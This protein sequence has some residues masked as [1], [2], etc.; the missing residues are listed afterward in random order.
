MRLP[1]HRRSLLAGV[2]L[3]GLLP[4]AAHAT[5][6]G[7][8]LDG[9]PVDLYNGAST[10]GKTGMVHC[11]DGDGLPRRD[12]EYRDGRQAGTMRWFYKGVLQKESRTNERGNVDG[13]SRT[14]AATPGQKNQLM[15]EETGRNGTTVGL[16]RDWY[17]DGMLQRLSWHLDDGSE[18]AVAGFTT[19]GK[20]SDLRCF[21]QPVFAPDFDDVSACGFKGAKTVELF[22]SKGWL[23]ARVVFDH[24]ERRHIENLWENGKPQQVVELGSA[25]GSEN[26][27][28]ED[29]GKRRTVA[30]LVQPSGI[31]GKPGYR[32]VTLQQDFH[33]SGTLVRERHWTPNGRGADLALDETW[34]LNGQLKTKD[35]FLLQDGQ[36]VKRATTFF[37]NGKV[38]ATGVWL[39]K[40]EYDDHPIGVH[41]RF[42]DQGRLRGE[43]SYDARGRLTRER[44]LDESGAVVTDDQVFEDGSRKAF[45]K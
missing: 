38:D 5:V 44:A 13:L 40:G 33:E 24:G 7:C 18:A 20:L 26:D 34:Y 36:R 29:G 23:A 11:F 15:H 25:N 3:L 17:P 28:A 31:A 21:S 8:T 37:D 9:Q 22:A 30:W 4:L 2:L 32:T 43:S 41:Q 10:A 39:A 6:N 1:R 12:I 45:A 14:Y 42:D 35:E 27:F 19:G 16:V